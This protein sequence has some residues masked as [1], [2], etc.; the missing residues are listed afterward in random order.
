[1]NNTSVLITENGIAIFHNGTH[2]V[3]GDD[4]QLFDQISE[5]VKNKNYDRVLELADLRQ[6]VK[7]FL[8]PDNA[9]TLENDLIVFEGRSF[10][11]AVTDKVLRMIQGGNPAAPLYA[12]LRNVRQ[13]PSVVAQDEL[14]LF[15]AANGF[16]ITEDGFILAYKKVTADYKDCHTGTV[17]N[18][19]GQKPSMAREAVDPDRDRTCSR[20]FHFAAYNHA[21]DFGGAHLMLLRVNPA[22]VVAIPSDY[23]NEKGRVGRTR[24]LGNWSI[25]NPLPKA[26]VYSST[27]AVVGEEP[28]Y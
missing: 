15:C 19:V 9:F 17:D 22:D 25:R 10:S 28:R 18:S 8:T 11:Q 4:H 27:G 20:G 24:S 21:K 16:M 14:L 1:M 5:A 7:A 6:S 3:I 2:S 12:F 23:D 13:N 26:E